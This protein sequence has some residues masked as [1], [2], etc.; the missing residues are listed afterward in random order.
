MIIRWTANARDDLLATHAY[1]AHED[2]AAADR[3]ARRIVSLVEDQLPRHPHSGRPGRIAGTRELV[4]AGAPYVVAYRVK[5]AVIDILGVLHTAR[6]W[7]DA[8]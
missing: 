6:R 1:V 2:R 4:V 8:F 3:L 7:P 5:G